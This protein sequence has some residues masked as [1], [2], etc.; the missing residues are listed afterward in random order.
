MSLAEFGEVLRVGELAEVVVLSSVKKKAMNAHSGSAILKD[1]L[2]LFYPVVK[3]HGD[4][5]SEKPP[6]RL[7]PDRGVRHK[8]G[9]VPGTKYCVT[10]QW[11]L[12]KEQ[13]EVNDAF[14]RAKHEA[15][16]V[17]EIKSM[18]SNAYIL[19]QKAE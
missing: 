14:F 2:D 17:H 6:S 16:M 11:H 13:C 8:I 18:E 10:R 4:V 3:E 12:P 1:P 9:L 19:R 5:V 7:T 15:D